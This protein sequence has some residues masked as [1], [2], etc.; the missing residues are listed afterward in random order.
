MTT[1]SAVVVS[2]CG[3]SEGVSGGSG[4][5]TIFTVDPA[6]VGPHIHSFSIP[7]ST[8]QMPPAGGF[9]ASTTSN[10][11]HSHSITL[12]QADLMDIEAGMAVSDST[13]IASAHLHAFT[14]P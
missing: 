9:T 12:T 3:N 7:N 1:L 11:G 10:S 13:T 8:L 6:G 5:T 4:G 14:F 2:G